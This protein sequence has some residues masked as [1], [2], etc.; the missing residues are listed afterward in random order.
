MAGARG[1]CRC[2]HI[3][4]F[5]MER[6]PWRDSWRGGGSDACGLGPGASSCQLSQKLSGKGH[7]LPPASSRLAACGHLPLAPETCVGPLTSRTRWQS[8]IFSH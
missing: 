1:P 6:L 5:E 8:V 3:K 2:G 4:D 7:M